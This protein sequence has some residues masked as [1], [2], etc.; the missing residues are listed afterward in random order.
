[1]SKLSPLH[2]LK[3]PTTSF[4]S[5]YSVLTFTKVRRQGRL[6]QVGTK[7]I[8]HVQPAASQPPEHTTRLGNVVYIQAFRWRDL[9][10][11]SK[12]YNSAA[13]TCSY[14]VHQAVTLALQTCSVPSVARTAWWICGATSLP[15]TVLSCR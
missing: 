12:A 3:S 4:F 8:A 10:I 14:L 1:M 5:I 6:V 7:L 13:A 11:C 15:A 2:A 9:C